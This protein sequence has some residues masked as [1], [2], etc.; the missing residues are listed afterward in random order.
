MGGREMKP[1]AGDKMAY[2]GNAEEWNIVS[3]WRKI[4]HS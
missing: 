2:D 4:L 3:G 1:K